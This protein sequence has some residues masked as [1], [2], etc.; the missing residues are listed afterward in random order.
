[1]GI[2]EFSEREKILIQRLQGNI[3]IVERPFKSL[4]D[5]A[6]TTEEEV[7]NVVKKWIEAGTIRRFGAVVNHL[8]AGKTANAL[9]VWKVPPERIDEVGEIISLY[10]EVTHCYERKTFPNWEFNIYAMIHCGNSEE[11]ESV[12]SSI[13][14]RTGI[15]KYLLLY[16]DREYKKQSPRYF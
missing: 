8:K 11:C 14:K 1:M 10:P 5:E 15:K 4:A 2:R 9:S 3:P 7:I 16:S 13:S 12:A 6:G